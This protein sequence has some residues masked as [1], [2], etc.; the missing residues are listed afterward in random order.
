[1]KGELDERKFE[2][3]QTRTDLDAS[4]GAS[5]E[6]RSIVVS[7][8][9]DLFVLQLDDRD[10]FAWYIRQSESPEIGYP[11]SPRLRHV[12]WQY[13][14]IWAFSLL[15]APRN[16]SL[17]SMCCYMVYGI[18]YEGLETL[19]LINYDIKRKHWVPSRAELSRPDPQTFETDQ[20]RFTEVSADDDGTW[21][22]VQ[23]DT[24]PSTR[25]GFLDFVAELQWLVDYTVETI[26]GITATQQKVNIKILA[27][28]HR[29]L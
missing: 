19:W 29:Q 2:V 6:S 27:C 28:E 5:L 15:E 12:G 26:R 16:S 10:M 7:P 14:P 8:T 18:K 1:M 21:D 24:R 25:I 3:I 22:E 4:S 23:D 17:E 20:F 13:N 9:E 11:I